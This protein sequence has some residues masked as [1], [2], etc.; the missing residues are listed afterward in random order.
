MMLSVYVDCRQESGERAG[1]GGRRESRLL[2]FDPRTWTREMR[3][4]DRCLTLLRDRARS[5]GL[6]IEKGVT[7]GQGW[8]HLRQRY[9]E[10]HV[11]RRELRTRKTRSG[12]RTPVVPKSAEL[13]ASV[14]VLTGG[15]CQALLRV[16]H[17]GV[18]E[19]VVD[20]AV[21]FLVREYR[22]EPALPQEEAA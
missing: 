22:G 10:A 15:R 17:P 3:E 16:W 6:I 19:R 20:A 13:L 11:V 18:D 5:R 7:A 14:T 1:T 8:W 21:R 4:L 2:T 12:H 9:L